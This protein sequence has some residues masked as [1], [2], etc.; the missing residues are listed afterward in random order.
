MS[1]LAH[2]NQQMIPAD[3]EHFLGNITSL[4]GSLQTLGVNF[5]LA[6]SMLYTGKVFGLLN[7]VPTQQLA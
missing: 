6:D 3:L 1:R 5:E 2:A 7:Q 4:N